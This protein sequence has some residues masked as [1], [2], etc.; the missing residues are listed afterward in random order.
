MHPEFYD[1][2]KEKVKREKNKLLF[3]EFLGKVYLIV[4]FTL[5]VSV[6]V[7]SIIIFALYYKT[8]LKVII[9]F[10]THN[11][12]RTILAC[13]LITCGIGTTIFK[14]KVFLILI[15]V[16]VVVLVFSFALPLFQPL[17]DAYILSE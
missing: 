12:G 8:I 2:I 14:S 17:I 1:I 5:F 13:I 15:G 4:L 3:K 10:L 16:T 9:S 6:L 7:V 11:L